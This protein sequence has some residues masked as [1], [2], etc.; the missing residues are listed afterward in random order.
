MARFLSKVFDEATSSLDSHTEREIQSSLDELAS[1]RTT[2][3]IAHR[4]STVIHAD[5]ILVLHQG[6]ALFYLYIF[7]LRPFFSSPNS[8]LP[9][10]ACFLH[11]PT[12]EFSLI[13][14]NMS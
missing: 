5:Q 7:M 9:S 6:L 4:L 2:I 12:F 10:S 13:S 3:I 14:S 8:L 11:G 1:G